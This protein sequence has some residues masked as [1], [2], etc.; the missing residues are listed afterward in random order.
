M[1]I[2]SFVFNKNQVN[3]Y[4]VSDEITKETLIIDCGCTSQEDFNKI[5][6][7][8]NENKLS[9]KYIFCTHLHF[10]HMFG[11]NYIYDKYHI[12]TKACILDYDLLE[13]NK[14]CC[15]LMGLSNEEKEL[16]STEHIQWIEEP[17]EKLMIGDNV[18]SV[19]PT[20]GHSPGSISFH[21]E[22]KKVIFCGDVLF[23]NGQGR[24]DFDGGDSS[25][26][27]YSIEYILNL[28]KDTLVLP[29][30]YQTFRVKNRLPCNLATKK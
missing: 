3:T 18:F 29:G 17:Y 5:V 8:V 11:I 30:H 24:T 19:I 14:L 7:Y 15:V 25:T 12:M 4:I 26:L 27:K 6:S 10:D 23:K 2:Q 9:L 21:C 28:D 13:W 20:P 22:S 16:L 1:I